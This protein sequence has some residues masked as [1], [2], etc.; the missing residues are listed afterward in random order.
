MLGFKKSPVSL[1]ID[2][3]AVEWGQ[4]V[5]QN[6]LGSSSYSKRP[7]WRCRKPSGRRKPRRRSFDKLNAAVVEAL[8][9]ATVRSRLAGLGE[10]IFSPDQQTPESLAVLHK[11]ELEK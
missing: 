11:A 2:E 9:N 1:S 4:R 5:A 10:K 6:T 8:A 7:A 3:A